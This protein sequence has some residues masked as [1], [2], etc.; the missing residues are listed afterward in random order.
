VSSIISPLVAH[1]FRGLKQI[2]GMIPLGLST[3]YIPDSVTVMA[4][5]NYLI[6]VG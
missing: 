3:R 4:Q 5:R 1:R 2:C 6:P